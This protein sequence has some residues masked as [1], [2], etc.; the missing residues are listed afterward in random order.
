VWRDDADYEELRQRLVWNL[1]KP[2][3]YPDVLVRATDEQDVVDAVRL[4]RANNLRIKVRG[5]GHSRSGSFL[6]E[7]GMLLD[8]SA[9]AD[10]SID[11]ESRVAVVGP[12]VV[13]GKLNPALI[14]HGLFFP[15]AH[16]P[17]VGLGGYVMAGGIGW[18]YP[19]HGLGSANLRAIDLVTA[20]GDMVHSDDQTNPEY[21]W[22]ARGAG[23]G[24]FGVVTRFHL[25]LH[26]VPAGI[27]ISS[28]AYPMDVWEDV[29]TWAMAIGPLL[30]RDVAANIGMP[31]KA[32]GPFSDDEP[33]VIL[34][35][36]AMSDTEEQADEALQIFE[37]CPLID[38]ALVR[39][40]AIPRTVGDLY[41]WADAL[42]PSGLRYGLDNMWTDATPEQLIP[43]LRRVLAEIPNSLS[44]IHAHL[45][46]HPQTVTN[47]ALSDQG[48]LLLSLFGMWQSDADE[49][50]VMKW[51]VDNLARMEP[52]AKGLMIAEEELILR[53]RANVLSPENM[54]R[55]QE[56][57][58][59]LDPDG[60]FHTFP[61]TYDGSE[62]AVGVSATGQ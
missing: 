13:A 18:V 46:H 32:G 31:R 14:E 7:D 12:G 51:I 9:M 38:R 33:A 53:P 5:T 52:L 34:N 61:G 19:R 41:T 59:K 29:W 48:H 25:G 3:R 42:Q 60:V 43:E 35:A 54:R 28:Y 44:N 26:P 58:S 40:V 30:P 39:Q 1:R 56:Y 24:F 36:T 20:D 22:A 55:Y 57:R 17:E 11:T 21:I 6:R 16:E 49:P 8:L 2:G 45:W 10:I 47:A 50:T 37:S 4:A 23:P 27:R 62:G 15:T